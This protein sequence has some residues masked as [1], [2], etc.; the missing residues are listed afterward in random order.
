MPHNLTVEEKLDKYFIDHKG[1]TD[2]QSNFEHMIKVQSE[3]IKIVKIYETTNKT[4]YHNAINALFR[5]EHFVSNL[6]KE[7]VEVML[8]SLSENTK[9]RHLYHNTSSFIDY[10]EYGDTKEMSAV[11]KQL[12]KESSVELRVFLRIIRST[13][14]NFVDAEGKLDKKAYNSFKIETLF[15]LMETLYGPKDETAKAIVTISPESLQKHIK[16]SFIN[17]ILRGESISVSPYDPSLPESQ[18]EP[19]KEEKVEEVKDTEAPKDVLSYLNLLSAVEEKPKFEKNINL[20]VGDEV[21]KV[22]KTLTPFLFRRMFT[23]LYF[24]R[25]DYAS[26]PDEQIERY[27]KLLSYIILLTYLPTY[28]SMNEYQMLYRYFNKIGLFVN[29]K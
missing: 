21:F 20:T 23:L 29:Y 19:E 26:L 9:L 3:Y 11:E 24:Y 12:I 7:H 28:S 10:L 4:E 14:L 6:K 17:G 1:F 2:S 27:K 13:E 15:K 18:V 25:C 5:S 16:T 8:S 22:T